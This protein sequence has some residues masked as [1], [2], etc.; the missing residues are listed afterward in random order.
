MLDDEGNVLTGAGAI[1]LF[2]SQAAPPA[3]AESIHRASEMT[4]DPR[5][6]TVVSVSMIEYTVQ[7]RL[8]RSPSEPTLVV[9]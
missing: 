9:R 4:E 7:I 3:G 1:E 5:T 8:P 6:H 2:D